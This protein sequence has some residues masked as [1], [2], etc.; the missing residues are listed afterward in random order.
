MDDVDKVVGDLK[1]MAGA[2]E[3]ELD[4]EL[5][6]LSGTHKRVEKTTEKAHKN[7]YRVNRMV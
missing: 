5:E 1:A 3:S 2:M 6:Q 7:A 4:R